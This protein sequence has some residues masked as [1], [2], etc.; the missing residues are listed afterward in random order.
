MCSVYR[1]LP[2]QVEVELEMNVEHDSPDPTKLE[3]PLK[4]PNASRVVHSYTTSGPP[5]F[6]TGTPH[7]PEVQQEVL[8]TR[9]EDTGKVT[10][11][12]SQ[13]EEK[14]PKESTRLP[15]TRLENGRRVCETPECAEAGET[16]E[17]PPEHFQWFWF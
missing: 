10:A 7:S 14:Q 6:Q 5:R 8:A 12:E 2:R 1:P 17:H 15:T 4:N 9:E 3:S 13:K 11:K 16:A